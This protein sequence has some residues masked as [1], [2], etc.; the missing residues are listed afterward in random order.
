M[1]DQEG[2]T[3]G[4]PA[5]ERR[6]YVRLDSSKVNIAPPSGEATWFKLIGVW[7]ENGTPDYP[8]GDEVE[9]V[10]SWPVGERYDY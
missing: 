10:I 1:S 2:D 5:E 9:T 3:F 7:L 6:L 4:I 8:Q